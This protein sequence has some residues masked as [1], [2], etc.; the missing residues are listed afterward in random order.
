MAAALGVVAAVRAAPGSPPVYDGCLASPYRVLGSTPAPGSA[1]EPF[2]ATAIST[3][4][5]VGTGEQPASQA[6]IEAPEGLLSSPSSPFRVSV[7][8]ERP[9]AAAPAGRR[10]DGNAYRVVAVTATGTPLQ[11]QPGTPGAT[12]L[13]RA[14]SASGGPRT[15]AVLVG[16]R[17]QTLPTTSAGCGNAFLAQSQRLGDFALLAHALPTARHVPGAGLPA[18]LIA[19]PS[20]AVLC[21]AIVLLLRLRRPARS[22]ET[23]R[24]PGDPPA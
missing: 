19:L 22:T 21:A 2:A 18:W 12:I 24:R 6:V 9:P 4:F 8:P 20:A 16:G 13:L 10:V 15:V 5:A 23:E 1:S 17:W 14:T 3:P 7:T 11:P